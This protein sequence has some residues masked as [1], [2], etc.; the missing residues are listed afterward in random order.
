MTLYES[1][2]QCLGTCPQGGKNISLHDKPR[3]RTSDVALISLFTS[4]NALAGLSSIQFPLSYEL[5]R[6][7]ISTNL[8]L[9]EDLEIKPCTLAEWLHTT[10]F[11]DEKNVYFTETEIQAAGNLLQS[12][13]QYRP[14]RRPRAS[15]ILNHRWFRN[16]RSETQE[17]L[18]SKA[19][20]S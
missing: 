1:G 16:S 18:N 6:K 2:Y 20:G 7:V 4:Y 15:Q 9:P 8:K 12:T 3:V 5:L 17:V 19:S 11:D 13:M 10:Y 14:S